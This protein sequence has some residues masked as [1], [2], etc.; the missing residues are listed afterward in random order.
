MIKLS[1]IAITHISLV[2][3]GAN[4]K[5][6]IYKSA[7]TDAPYENRISIKKTDEEQG[8][9]YGIVYSPDEVDSQGDMTDVSEIKKAA[10]AFMKAKNVGNV[11]VN[12]DFNNTDAFV[13]ESWIVKGGDEI[14]PD[15]KQG[16][17]AVAIQLESEE[18]KKMAKDGEIAGLSMAGTAE[19]TEVAKAEDSAWKKLWTALGESISGFNMEFWTR[20]EKGES[21]DMDKY[22]KELKEK[23]QEATGSVEK[24]VEKIAEEADDAKQATAEQAK[25][26]KALK[27]SNA[28]KDKL[29]KEQ[30]EK[31]EALTKDVKESGEKTAEIEETLKKSSQNNNPK[32]KKL[33]KEDD[34]KGV[35]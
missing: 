22:Q 32:D 21:V 4:G 12:H 17:W 5:S 31:L 14:F 16:S 10:Y 29:I 2:K 28:D 33:E 13:A 34:L 20:I 11:D 3:S 27:K 26:I 19:K 1:N 8:V 7:D 35:V 6:I 25:E 24:A 30:G 9:V 18:L 23:L 15:E